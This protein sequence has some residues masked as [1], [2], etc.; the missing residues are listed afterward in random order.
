MLNPLVNEKNNQADRADL[1]RTSSPD[2]R[3]ATDRFEAKRDQEVRKVHEQEVQLQN[4]V[5]SSSRAAWKRVMEVNGW[6]SKH[7][8]YR[9]QLAYYVVN[10]QSYV[11]S[12]EFSQS[13]ISEIN[14]L[15]SYFAKN[16][17]SNTLPALQALASQYPPRSAPRDR[18]RDRKPL[19]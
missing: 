1:D 10:A 3:D 15:R 17:R 12:A 5:E 9:A 13:E 14:T 2:V 16:P 6:K 11:P 8:N 19:F 7:C 18:V 4:E